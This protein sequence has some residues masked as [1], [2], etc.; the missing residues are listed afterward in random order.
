MPSTSIH[1]ALLFAHPQAV[2]A[3]WISR[4]PGP[5]NWMVCTH[6]TATAFCGSR[7]A[8]IRS[9]VYTHYGGPYLVVNTRY[10]VGPSIF[11]EKVGIYQVPG[12]GFRASCRPYLICPPV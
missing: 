4:E 3:A 9:R 12:I 2:L 1:T 5:V 6:E 7:R 11:S 10:L 8:F